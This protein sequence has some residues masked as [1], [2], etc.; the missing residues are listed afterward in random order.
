MDGLKKQRKAADAKQSAKTVQE[1][2]GAEQS[3][4]TTRALSVWFCLVLL[5]SALVLLGSA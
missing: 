5:G 4:L 1:W 2:E 3:C